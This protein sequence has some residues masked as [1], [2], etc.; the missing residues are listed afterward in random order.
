MAKSW[1]NSREYRMWRAKVIRRD[2][3]CQLCNSI[4]GRQAHHLNSASYFPDERFIEDNG[5]CLCKSCHSMF[6]VSYK[7]SYRQKCTKAD[8]A[9]FLELLQKLQDKKLN[10]QN[11]SNWK[12]K[13]G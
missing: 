5:I 12:E 4:K 9:N 13:I 7:K 11:I 3:R 8:F 2:K 10:Y 6:H 1:R